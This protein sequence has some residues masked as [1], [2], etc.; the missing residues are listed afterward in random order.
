MLVGA[1][2]YWQTWAGADLAN[3]QD[4]AV[5]RVV[6]LSIDRGKILA[7]NGAV[8]AENRVHRQHGLTIYTRRYPSSGLFSQIVGYSTAAGTQ[9]GLEQSLND[10]LTGANTNLS[11]TFSQE[12]DRLGGETVHGDSVVLTVR[13][14]VQALALHDLAGRCGAVVALDAKT[15]AVL[16]LASSPTYDQN[17][18]DRPNGFAKIAKVKGTCG[19]ASAL[20]DY[21]TQGRYPPGSTFKMITASAALD[22]GAVKPTSGFYDPG[23]CTEYGKPVYNSSSPDSP[24]AHE[25]FGNV[26]FAQAFEHSINAVF[27]NVGKQIG[28]GKILDYAKR[29]GFYSLAAARHAAGRARR[30]RPLQQGQALVADA[31]RRRRSTRAGSPSGRS[32]CSSRRSRWRSS[33]RRSR[34]AV[35]SR[36]RTSS[37]RSSRRTGRPSSR[38][39]PQFL[40]RPI[41][42][43]TA[44]ELNQMMQLVVAG[45][46]RHERADPRR[47]G[48]GQDR[49]RG[50]RARQRLRRVVRLLRPGEQP[51]VRRRSRR[52]EAARRL[53]RLGLGAHRQGH[54]RNSPAQVNMPL[55]F[56]RPWR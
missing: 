56:S 8:L 47:S 22:T 16:A 1:T 44:A 13:P 25:T 2:T 28:A 46:H 36:S 27:C 37:R 4:N 50:G 6:Q 40:G 53:R 15:G 52:R 49:H 55:R 11:N 33:R 48:R 30:Q 5:E 54:P 20:Y 18:I 29:Y 39:A 9:V 24:T 42:P 32:G 7:A 43:Q 31:T 41:K 34:T 38:R 26:D 51:A 14:A 35:A 3:R 19:D 45:R 12:L 21:A 10:Y 17:L 23:Y